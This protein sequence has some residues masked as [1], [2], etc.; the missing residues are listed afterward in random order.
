MKHDALPDHWK[1]WVES[2]TEGRKHPGHLSA[3]DFPSD[4]SVHLVFPDGSTC[5]FRYAFYV[6]D[7]E[8]RELAV[9]TEHC[10]YHVFPIGDLVYSLM[11]EEAEE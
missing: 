10:G 3:S 7:D 6:A 8:R 4:R 2:Y 1:Q 9:F 5:L 11:D